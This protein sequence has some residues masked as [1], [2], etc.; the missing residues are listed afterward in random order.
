MFF[1]LELIDL[2]YHFIF[3]LPINWQNQV[4]IWPFHELGN[5]LWLV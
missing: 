4:I 5:S 2:R 1:F 3:I